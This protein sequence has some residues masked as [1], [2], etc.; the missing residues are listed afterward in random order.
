MAREGAILERVPP[1]VV[2]DFVLVDS[3][4]QYREVNVA[5]CCRYVRIPASQPSNMVREGEMRHEWEGYM[6]TDERRR[7][8]NPTSSFLDRAWTAEMVIDA[9][10]GMAERPVEEAESQEKGN[11][12]HDEPLRGDSAR[13]RR[14]G[15]TRQVGALLLGRP[16]VVA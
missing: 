14:R 15:I 7:G 12:A 6:L 5:V 1:L 3:P 13:P 2:V 16:L 11:N 10:I 8:E 9:V 4:D